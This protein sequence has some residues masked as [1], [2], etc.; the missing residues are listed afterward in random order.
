MTDFEKFVSQNIRTTTIF[1][2]GG[3]WS[4]KLEIVRKVNGYSEKAK[5][6]AHY[7]SDSNETIITVRGV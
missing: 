1:L 7:Y 2:M 5:I 6:H 4:N 3:D